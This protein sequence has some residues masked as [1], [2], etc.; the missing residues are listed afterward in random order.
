[1]PGYCIVIFDIVKFFLIALQSAMLLRVILSWIPGADDNILSD[2]LYTVT[3]PVVVPF[4]LLF[5]KLGLFDDSPFDV[6]FFFTGLVVMI[7]LF[8]FLSL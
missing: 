8:V 2:F 3:E 7:L 5:E 4:R 1:M 6:P